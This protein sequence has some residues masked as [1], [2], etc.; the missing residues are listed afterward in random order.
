MTSGKRLVLLTAI[1]Y[2]YSTIKQ[3][4]DLFERN[5]V[6]NNCLEIFE[7]AYKNT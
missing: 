4:N 3:L 7:A 2:K 5:N 6:V 1:R